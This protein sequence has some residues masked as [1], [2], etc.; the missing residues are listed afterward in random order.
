MFD[1]L[2]KLFSRGS[3]EESKT[4]SMELIDEEIDDFERD[5][6]EYMS[7]TQ[8]SPD[9]PPQVEQPESL[10]KGGAIK[11]SSLITPEEE[12]RIMNN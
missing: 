11:G 7:Y 6:Q 10:S 2:K 5:I 3:K 1:S 12:K 9:G 8:E 4:H